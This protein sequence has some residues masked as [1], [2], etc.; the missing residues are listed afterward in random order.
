MPEHKPNIDMVVLRSITGGHNLVRIQ[1]NHQVAVGRS[2]LVTRTTAATSSIDSC[3]GAG[4]QRRAAYSEA[5]PNI[6]NSD[7]LR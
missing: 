2:W 3:W 7:L 4:H 5:K 1:N 6:R